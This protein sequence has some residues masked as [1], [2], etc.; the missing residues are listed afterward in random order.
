MTLVF[1]TLGV[2]AVRIA[3]G[4]DIA[5]ACAGTVQPD[6]GIGKAVTTS[7][8]RRRYYGTTLG[9]TVGVARLQ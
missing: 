1:D 5:V 8:K 9:P 3:H 2:T 7:T 6:G 4:N